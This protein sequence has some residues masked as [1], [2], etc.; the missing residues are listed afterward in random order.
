MIKKG[1]S[2]SGGE[3][4]EGICFVRNVKYGNIG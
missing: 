2:S 1:K 4:N 3:D